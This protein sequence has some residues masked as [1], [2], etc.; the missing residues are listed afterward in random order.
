G[1]GCSSHA[2][3]P[4]KA[5]IEPLVQIQLAPGS[6]SVVELPKPVEFQPRKTKLPLR[7]GEQR[8]II[9]TCEKGT[10]EDL[11]EMKDIKADIDKIKAVNPNYLDIAARD[12]FRHRDVEIVADAVPATRGF[13]ISKANKGRD[14]Q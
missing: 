13:F 10:V 9:A 4:F 6:A 1:G 5:K 11:D 14:S 2:P 7:M 3:S 8:L 12:V